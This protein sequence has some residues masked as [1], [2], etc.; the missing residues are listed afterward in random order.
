[1]S[2]KQLVLLAS[3]FSYRTSA[4]EEAAQKLGIPV[5]TA[6]DVPPPI[7]GRS[8]APLVVDYRDLPKAVEQITAYAQTHPVG[9]VVGLDDSGARIAAAA[10][11]RLGIPYNRPEAAQAAQDKHLMRQKFALA[12]V[13][14]PQFRLF[15]LDDDFEDMLD[16]VQYPCVI[17][18]TGLS[19]SRGVM[20]ADHPLDLLRCAYRLK[21]ILE[22]EGCDTFLVEDYIPGVEVA[23]E[24]L[25]TPDGLHVLALFDKPDPLEGPFFE[26]TIYVTPSRL[27]QET[28]DDIVRVTRLA[29][30][31][32]GLHT[33]PVHAELR[34]NEQ[35][36]WLVEVAARSIGG[37]CSR[38]LRFGPPTHLDAISLEELILRQA[39]DLPL[40]T[41]REDQ[42]SGVMMIP[43]PSSGMLQGVEGMEAALAV[44]GVTEIEMSIQP[45]Q[46]VKTLPEGSAYLGFIF[47]RGETPAGVEAALRAAHRLLTF[48]IT[49]DLPLV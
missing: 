11:D 18:P 17:K 3:V 13:P 39:F 23:L 10:C 5:V 48:Q 2:Q 16:Q 22:G 45:G 27:P 49:P 1:M 43:I 4:F 24:G 35:G 14:S 41:H 46:P 15:H 34:V 32:L 8:N 19:G 47:A 30:A 7:A 25:L 6:R 28:Q 44:P 29:A 42:A 33:G 36:V 12:G 37:Q 20:R 26:E 31:A 38:A 9:A 21:P 40:E